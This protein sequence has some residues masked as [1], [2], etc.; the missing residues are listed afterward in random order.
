[1]PNPSSPRV[2]WR[3]IPISSPPH[4]AEGV[5]QTRWIWT[6]SEGAPRVMLAAGMFTGPEGAGDPAT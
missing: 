5:A 3:P 6:A 2:A 4:C 1:E